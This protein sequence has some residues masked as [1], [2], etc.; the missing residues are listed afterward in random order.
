MLGLPNLVLVASSIIGSAA[1]AGIPEPPVILHGTVVVDGRII[2]RTD[3]VTILARVPEA[4]E[5]IGTYHMGGNPRADDDYVLRL[6][7]EFLVDG[8][9]QSD[10]AAV[11]GQTATISVCLGNGPE[12]IAG[13][14]DISRSGVIENVDLNVTSEFAHC[15]DDDGDIDLDDYTVFSACLSGV[16]G[17]IALGCGCADFDKDG[18]ANLKDWSY[19]QLLFTGPQ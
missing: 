18:N 4:S 9:P 15:A 10:A 16:D 13:Q 12:R 5:S 3:D 6:R 17:E 19:F 14:F 7:I 2:L 11:V 8:E 1:I